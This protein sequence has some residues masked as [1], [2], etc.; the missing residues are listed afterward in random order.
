[1]CKESVL[2]ARGGVGGVSRRRSY[3]RTA[4]AVLL[5]F[6]LF[7]PYVLEHLGSM[8]LFA[9]AI[10]FGALALEVSLAELSLRRRMVIIAVVGAY[11]VLAVGA[12]E[13]AAHQIGDRLFAVNAEHLFVLLPLFA[14]L[15]WVLYRSEGGRIYVHVFLS[16][17]CL[18]GVLAVSESLLNQSLFGRQ[19]EFVTSQREGLARA[20]VG[21]EN[22]LVS[23]AILAAM[24][25]FVLKLGRLR[26]QV[27]G[28]VILV[29][30][31][32]G[33]GSRAPAIICTVVAGVQLF[34]VLRTLLVRFLWMIHAL[35]A[36]AIAGLAYLSVFVWTPY[37]AGATGLEYSS[38]YRGALYSLVP[39][40]LAE[41][42]FGY[43][44]QSAPAGRWLVGSELHGVFDI[45]RSVDSEIVYAIFGL[46]WIG[47]AFFLVAL[48][49]SIG[50]IKHDVAIGLSALTLTSLGS[51]LALHAWDAMSP[52][53]YALLGVCVG[54]VV[55]PRFRRRAHRG[56]AL[57]LGARQKPRP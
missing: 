30:G 27:I 37:I 19:E 26:T 5:S 8:R 9:V 7:F 1:M 6:G 25:P 40:V 41:R 20:L 22:S 46:G 54:V 12:V 15:G 34:P 50:A 55:L 48:F 45:A 3:L 52:L 24:I 32:W 23:G 11:L 35:A 56:P 16:V 49:I 31:V 47:L 57:S 29:S 53:W 18:V 4:S 10:G 36:A 13:L 44:L 21:S 28:S 2:K 39:H 14:L 17:A 51:V 33:T 43:L 38:S 42:P